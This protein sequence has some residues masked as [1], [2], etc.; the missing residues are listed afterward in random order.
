[1]N[2][3]S[4]IVEV[5]DECGRSAAPGSEGLLLLTSLYN[6][7][8]PL[9]RYRIGDRGRFLPT[10]VDARCAC[11]SR[12]PKLSLIGG[13]DDDYV[14]L[15]SGQLI[16]PR[17]ICDTVWRSSS[18]I[19]PA[20]DVAWALQRFRVEQDA[21]DHLTV[22]VVCRS[23]QPSALHEAIAHALRDLDPELRC[24]VEPVDDLAP[25][26]SGKFRRVIRSWSPD[27]E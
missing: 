2:T 12:R 19:T 24:S 25:E 5:V 14:L 17:H 7:T 27:P 3:D 18:T 26:P 8:M 9:I 11:G 23:R 10:H 22:R 1:V 13:R 21:G 4:C 16:S 20:T 15:P 6:C